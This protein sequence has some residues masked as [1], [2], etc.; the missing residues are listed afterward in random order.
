MRILTVFSAAALLLLRAAAS[1]ADA[2]PPPAALYVAPEVMSQQKAFNRAIDAVRPAV[3]TVR[4]GKARAGSPGELLQDV[5]DIFGQFFYQPA[6]AGNNK[7]EAKATERKVPTTGSGVVITADGYILTN[8]HVVRGEDKVTVTFFGREGKPLEGTVIGR[9]GSSDI[10]LVKVSTG[11]TLPYAL[12][13]DSSRIS[14]GDW[15]IAVGSPFGLEQSATVGIISA[16]RQ[17]LPMGKDAFIYVIQTDA[18]INPGNSG[19]PLLNIRGEVI[20]I[21]MASYSPSGEFSGIGFAIPIN[22]AKEIAAELRKKESPP[23]PAPKPA[24]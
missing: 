9:D 17:K 7:A 2:T 4:A 21:N 20:G 5:E 6:P 18:R 24:S 14:A 10:A 16:V 23:A 13:G 12:L 1:A 22:R 19:G 3:V 8:E 15:A 11:G